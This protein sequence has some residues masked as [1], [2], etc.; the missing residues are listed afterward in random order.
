VLIVLFVCAI[1]GA[2]VYRA[3]TAEER[4]QFIERVVHPALLDLDDI[5]LAAAPFRAMLRERTPRLVA[6]P[7]LAGL[8][9]VVFLAMLFGDG[10]FAEPATLIAWGANTGPRTTNG[11]W[12]RLLTA[13]V[14]PTG[15]SH[16]LFILLG[17]LP[18]GEMLE[19]LLGAATVAGVFV[20]AGVLAGLV[21]LADHPLS[22]HAGACASV[23]GLHGLLLAV[24][25]YGLLRSGSL[26]I[27]VPIALLLL[28]ASA[29]FFFYSVVTDGLANR[30]NLTGLVAGAVTGVVL[31]FRVG[32]H[33]PHAHRVATCMGAAAALAVALSWPVRGIVD[34]RR[35]LVDLVADDDRDAMVFRGRLA[36]YTSHQRPIDTRALATLI[37]ETILPQL[38]VARTRLEQLATPIA[39][40]QPLVASAVEYVRLR[41]QSW[42][43]RVDGFRKG[44][45]EI[46][47][48]AERIERASLAALEKLRRVDVSVDVW[49]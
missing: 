49:M 29:L 31:A 27:P 37:E 38:T 26:V 23:Y 6:T 12:W 39:E 46:L 22:V 14:V 4:S 5:V 18:V 13:L 34:V 33:K 1:L 25:A 45:M 3:T 40:H 48:E 47:R 2:A 15:P 21:S 11:E 32:E 36:S 42:R 41:E 8:S 7:V 28:P 19:R 43:L 9:V 35:E 30:P 16:L 10:A 20:A 17:L 44:K 24:I